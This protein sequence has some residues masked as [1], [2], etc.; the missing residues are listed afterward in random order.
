M[1]EKKIKFLDLEQIEKLLLAPDV[2]T[3][4]GLRDRAILEVLFST[5]LRVAELVSLNKNQFD[6]KNMDFSHD[7]EL[8]IVGKG[9]YPRTVYFS[10][11]SL[12]FL[13]L[14]YKTIQN[15]VLF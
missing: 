9:G 7:Y 1:K 12:Q 4:I 6:F 5:G 11:R 13:K 15:Q 2:S 14:Y 10:P 3:L 8:M